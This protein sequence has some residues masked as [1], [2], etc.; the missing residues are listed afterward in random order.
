M[1]ANPTANQTPL[2]SFFRRGFLQT[3]KPYQ[4]Y[5]YFPRVCQHD[6]QAII[7]TAYLYRERFDFNC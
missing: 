4:R 7:R 1:D 2:F 5:R 3:R 6:P